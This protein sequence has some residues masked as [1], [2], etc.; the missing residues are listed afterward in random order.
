MKIRKINE[1]APCGGVIWMLCMLIYFQKWRIFEN[2]QDKWAWTLWWSHMNVAYTYVD[3]LSKIKNI[4]RDTRQMCMN[5]VEPYECYACWLTF[6]NEEYL[7][8]HTINEHEPCGTIWM[9]CML[10]NLQNQRIFED[11]Q[12]KWAF[13]WFTARILNPRIQDPE[14]WKFKDV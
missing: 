6:K 1:H 12:D 8:R 7:K 11:S 10:I 4:W 3:L 13:M 9:L 14:S 2:S 5:L